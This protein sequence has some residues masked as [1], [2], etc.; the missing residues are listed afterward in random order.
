MATATQDTALRPAR[1][2]LRLAGREEASLADALLSLLVHETVDGLSRC[3]ATFGNWGPRDGRSDFL[4]LDRR[5]LDFGSPLA[6]VLAGAVLFEGR[7]S[8]LEGTF[9][10]GGAPRV[11]VLAEDRFQDLRMTRRSRTFT[12]VSDADVLRRVAAEHGLAADVDVPGPRHRVVAQLDQSDLAFLRD[13]ARACSAELWVADGTLSARRRTARGG[14]APVVLA[15]GADL[16]E[17]RVVA[18]LAGQR[19]S[20]SV[21]GWDVAGKA[22]LTESADDAALAGEITGLDSGARVLGAAFAPRREAV[23]DAVPLSGPEARARAESLFRRRAR[24]FV[25][26]RGV[27]QTVAGLRVGTT[28]RL[29]RLGG[30]LGGEFHVV[31]VRHRFDGAAGL[32]TEFVAERAGVGRP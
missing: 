17:V 1:P 9:P 29:D 20:V 15:H 25:V 16:R 23:V 28:V 2:A 13:R 12:D 18:D 21:G 27:A 8:A 24:Q 30:L 11:T 22:A 10:S 7:I 4:Y 5:T 6:V 26:A 31:E 19:S 32:R 14:T 3:E